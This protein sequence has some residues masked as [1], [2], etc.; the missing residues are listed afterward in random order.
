VSQIQLVKRLLAAGK[1]VSSIAELLNIT[2]YRVNKLVAQAIQANMAHSKARSKLDVYEEVIEAAIHKGR[3]VK[4]IQDLISTIN[5]PMHY[6]TVA[7]YVRKVKLAQAQ[8]L[9]QPAPGEIAYLSL[10]KASR[11]KGE[12]N[13]LFSMMLGYSYYS[14]FAPV[15]ALCLNR[16]LRIHQAAFTFFGGVPSAILLC[17]IPGQCMS[18]RQLEFYRRFLDHYGVQL[19]EMTVQNDNNCIKHTQK[20]KSDVLC[21]LFP[22]DFKLFARTIQLKY[23]KPFNLYLHPITKKPIRKEFEVTEL[24]N[25]LPLPKEQFPLPIVVYRKTSK[26]GLV[27]YRYKHYKLPSQYKGQKIKVVAEESQLRFLFEGQEIA[28]YPY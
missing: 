21:G 19:K 25:L 1:S 17:E 9:L 27:C 10:L 28:C 20:V 26:R 14:Y 3:S 23:V 6:S 4:A 5:Q 24:P 18:K 11:R 2:R 8:Q 15:Q 13:Y 22:K 12:A 16:F 7:K